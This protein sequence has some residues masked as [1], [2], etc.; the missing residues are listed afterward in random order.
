MPGRARGVDGPRQLTWDAEAW[1]ASLPLLRV[2]AG[3][4]APASD[5]AAATPAAAREHVAGLSRPQLAQ[6][7]QAP[8]LL[9]TLCAAVQLLRAETEA[10]PPRGEGDDPTSAG[11]A[12]KQT[13]TPA[14]QK[15]QTLE[16]ALVE[17]HT[18]RQLLEALQR[19][20]APR[21]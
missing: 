20:G 17:S 10:P 2:L 3:S 8:R 19:E 14:V 15:S 18:H 4:L 1:L 13:R 6:L 12:T 5:G 21:R 11:E 7:L 9:D 16:S